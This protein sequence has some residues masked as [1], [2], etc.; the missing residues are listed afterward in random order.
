ML[1]LHI[2]YC[3]KACVYCDFHFSVNTNGLDRM[4]SAICR[5]IEIRK[6]YLDSSEPLKTVYFGGGTPS[7]L[8]KNH[9][10]RIFQTIRENYF[11]DVNAEITLEANPDDLT[12]EK[13][14]ELAATPINRLSIGIQSFF[15]DDLQFMNR[16]HS[17]QEAVKSIHNSKAAGFDNLSIDLIY[18]LPNSELSRWAKN[19]ELAF[20]L[21]VKHLSCY[22]LTLEPKTKLNKMVSLGQV[23]IPSD[24][25]FLEQFGYL[26]EAAIS[27][28]FEHYEISN[29]AKPGFRSNHNSRYWNDAHYVG[30]GPSAHSYNGISRQ[31]NV[32]SNSLYVDAINNG[33]VPFKLES[34]SNADKYNEYVMTRLRTLEGVHLEE[35]GKRFGLRFKEHF[36]EII[37]TYLNDGSVSS[38]NNSRFSLT[39]KGQ[40]IADRIAA[41]LFWTE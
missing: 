21:P 9:I 12:H 17:A 5:E 37:T 38:L 25:N 13:L 30:V 18:G 11:L 36:S 34:L 27:N 4:V 31:W 2:P 1:Y 24:E 32:S 26:M 41:D 19:L 22:G 39:R 3:K 16:A 10:E 40:F 8:G 20:S 28:G 15:D 23:A 35:L 6:D 29:F 33:E 14:A 7:I